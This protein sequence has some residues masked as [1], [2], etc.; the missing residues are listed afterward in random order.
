MRMQHH[1]SRVYIYIHNF[2]FGMSP[3]QL[4]RSTSR[5]YLRVAIRHI[6]CAAY[7]LNMAERPCDRT[8]LSRGVVFQFPINERQT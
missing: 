5:G 7:L 1:V 3:R 2:A 6:F 8:P 4:E